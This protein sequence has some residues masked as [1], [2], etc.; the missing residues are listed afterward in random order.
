MCMC[1][2]VR[3]CVSLYAVY[4]VYI[5]ECVYICVLCTVFPAAVL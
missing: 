1:L 5:Y 2:R 3:A 4:V